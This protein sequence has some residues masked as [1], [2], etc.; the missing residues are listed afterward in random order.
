MNTAK[1]LKAA[2]E[3]YDSAVAAALTEYRSERQ[4]I[5]SEEIEKQGATF[6]PAGSKAERNAEIWLLRE[7]G[8]PFRAI[9]EIF[10]LTASHMKTIYDGE[11]RRRQR[12]AEPERQKETFT[13][14]SLLMDPDWTVRTSNV[15]K[16]LA[17]ED[18]LDLR[19]LT[20]ADAARFLTGSRI[21]SMPNAGRK[22]S[23]EVA[24]V[25][26]A[27]GQPLSSR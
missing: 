4:T 18:G 16:E 24:D 6:D 13:G 3:R 15:L 21:R 10:G 22:V 9:G 27:A 12:E 8:M 23:N 5:L 1:R 19:T 17:H 20:I 14:A 7:Q 11:V 26:E 25:C 2:R